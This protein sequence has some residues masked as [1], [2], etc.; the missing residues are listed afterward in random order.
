MA[1]SPFLEIR[2][3]PLNPAIHTLNFGVSAF[4][5]LLLLPVSP[6]I[7]RRFALTGGTP[8]GIVL[9]PLWETEGVKFRRGAGLLKGNHLWQ[10]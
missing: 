3:H 2:V 4:Q 7:Q 8:I 6:A 5:L 9:L 1:I 10:N